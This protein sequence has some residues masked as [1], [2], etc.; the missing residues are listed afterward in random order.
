MDGKAE[1]DFAPPYTP[2]LNE[3]AETLM[4]TYKIKYV[5]FW[6][7]GIPPSLW[8]LATYVYNM[9]FHKSNNFIS[10]IAKLNPNAKDN[11]SKV[12]RF[13]CFAYAKIP[14]SDTKFSDRALKTI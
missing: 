12:R 10:P 7:S 13:G 6:D 3:T 11:F 1:T 9:T 8:I 5:A 14:L 4:T 2:Q